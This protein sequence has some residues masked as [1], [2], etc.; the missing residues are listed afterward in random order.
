ME[1]AGASLSALGQL[2]VAA[3][4]YECSSVRQ[5]PAPTQLLRRGYG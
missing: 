4:L 1:S 5:T 2:R 3:T